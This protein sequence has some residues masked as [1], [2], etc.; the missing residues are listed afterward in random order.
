MKINKIVYYM[1]LSFF[2]LHSLLRE[3]AEIKYYIYTEINVCTVHQ[4]CII[5]TFT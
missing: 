1:F 5:F 4:I 2:L 3:A